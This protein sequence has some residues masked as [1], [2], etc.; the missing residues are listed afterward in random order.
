MS[1][2]KDST[3]QTW[4]Q[5]FRKARRKKV[6][7]WGRSLTRSLASFLGRQSLVGDTPVLDSR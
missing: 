2:I 5:R 6:K 7:I 1:K 3:G 4:L